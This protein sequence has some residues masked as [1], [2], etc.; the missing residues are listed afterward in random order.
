M[1]TAIQ[2]RHGDAVRRRTFRAELTKLRTLR[3]TWITIAISVAAALALS[4]VNAASSAGRWDTMSQ[5]DR[6]QFDATSTTLIGV[7]FGSLVLGALAVRSITGE[8]STG[9]VKV[10]FA[11]IPERGRVLAAKTAL[12]I[13]VTFVVAMVANLGSF[14]LGQQILAS[15]EIQDSLG[16]P[17]VARSI[18]FGG[19]AVSCFAVIGI[20]LGTML[21]RASAAN[22]AL[23]LAVIG[24]QIVG[25]ALPKS[26]QRYLPFNAL[27]ATVS[28][29]PAPELLS[30]TPALAMLATYAVAL[31]LLAHRSIVSR[32]A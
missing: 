7:L 5:S 3:A 2:Q 13:A 30:P 4:A 28:V 14:I 24:G 25:T 15:K 6:V 26:A 19:L 23:S 9:M 31:F 1:T 29:K 12:L 21:K 17:G 16:D 11:A 8:Y 27:Q 20:G 32:D 10:T 22:I 18:V